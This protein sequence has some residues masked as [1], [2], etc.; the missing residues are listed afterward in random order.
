[1]YGVQP[2]QRSVRVP[3]L[4]ERDPRRDL[5]VSRQRPIHCVAFK[6]QAANRRG[7][8]L[9]ALVD[10]SVCLHDDALVLGR[11]GCLHS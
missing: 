3:A 5:I 8:W 1:M 10:P 2:W 11:A 7:M 6:G 9:L 4:L